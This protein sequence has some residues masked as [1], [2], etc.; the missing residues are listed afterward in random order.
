MSKRKPKK[1]HRRK[2]QAQQR[3]VSESI[4][5]V[6]RSIEAIR[7]H[8]TSASAI[9]AYLALLLDELW[10]PN[11]SAQGRHALAVSIFVSE[12]TCS[13]ADRSLDTYAEFSNFLGR[14]H[15]LLPTF[16]M[17]DDHVPELD[18]GQVRIV[19][20][21]ETYRMMYGGAFERMSDFIA[22]FRL[23]KK[24]GAPGRNDLRAVLT[25]Q[26][27]LLKNIAQTSE[28]SGIDADHLEVPPEEFWAQARK[29]LLSMTETT[30]KLT[31]SP[32]LI[33]R[34]GA[35]PRPV[36]NSFETKFMSGKLLP[37]ALLEMEGRRFPISPRSLCA[38]VIQHWEERE[39]RPSSQLERDTATQ[40]ADFLAAR[41]RSA[42]VIPGPMRV[43]LRQAK[44]LDL[45][46]AAL[47]CTHNALWVVVI[48]DVHRA[49]DLPA[50][51]NRLRA[52]IEDDDGLVAQDLATGQILHMPLQGRPADAVRVM[53]VVVTPIA[54][55]SVAFSQSSIVRSL[56][57]VDLVSIVESVQRVQDL[58]DYFAFVDSNEEAASPFI[59]HMDQFAAYR[60]SHG[61][62]IGGAIRPT[63]IML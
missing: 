50:A 52:L 29:V 30:A 46:V 40:A 2:F 4:K 22:S 45:Q 34:Q 14:L 9:G 20:E 27:H 56:F 3:S 47:L 44:L 1:P 54:G 28:V 31:V 49:K 35:I 25:L 55:A 12:K 37:F 42:D 16:P 11:I 10:L 61:V 38:V 5:S 13:F 41:F 36:G 24:G 15:E 43:S 21:G 19:F 53:A 48:I 63:M 6:D 58:E 33:A 51:A 17:M 32:A 18:W 23:A 26:D 7:A 39:S 62:L 8:L 57:L 60:H 59:G